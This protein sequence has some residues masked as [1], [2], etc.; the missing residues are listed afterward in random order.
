[1]NYLQY[2]L[3][4]IP[5]FSFSQAEVGKVFKEYNLNGSTTIYD[6]KYKKWFFTDKTDANK[7][8]LPASTFKIINSLIA[9]DLKVIADTNEV[10]KWDGQEKTFK[11]V[12]IEAWNKDTNMKEAFK[13]STVWFYVRLSNKIG[14]ANYRYYLKKAKYGN[15]KINNGKDGDFWNYGPFAISPVNQINFLKAFYDERLPFLQSSIR[16]VKDL[17]LVEKTDTYSIYAKSGWSYDKFDNGWWVGY[18]Q[19]RDNV[20]FFATRIIKCLDTLYPSFSD[21]RR[22]IT[23]QVFSRLR[24]INF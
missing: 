4:F 20:Y 2:L 14:L 10:V 9:L 13:N 5:I 22:Q 11:D 7:T 8:T 3:Y 17:M 23:K 18:I 21:V 24:I 16:K 6:Y 15:L 12:R 1:M 19:T